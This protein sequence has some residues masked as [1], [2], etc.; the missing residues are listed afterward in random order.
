MAL[1]FTCYLWKHF[2]KVDW[3]WDSRVNSLE[4]PKKQENFSYRSFWKFF[5][6]S[7]LDCGSHFPVFEGHTQSFNHC[8]RQQRRRSSCYSY[9]I[10]LLQGLCLDVGG[11][12]RA[13]SKPCGVPPLCPPLLAVMSPL[14]HF[15]SMPVAPFLFS[16]SELYCIWG[17]MWYVCIFKLTNLYC[18]FFCVWYLG[19]VRYRNS[20]FLIIVEGDSLV[21]L[22][23]NL[24]FLNYNFTCFW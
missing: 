22:W 14:V 16:T 9:C 23:L 6:I 21:F 17:C 7:L 15:S 10:L 11:D 5:V 19:K 3:H 8:F 2:L 4:W 13:H 18:V 20:M 1:Y 24:F 12:L